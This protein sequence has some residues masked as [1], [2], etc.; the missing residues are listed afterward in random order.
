MLGEAFNRGGFGGV[1]AA[2]L[3]AQVCALFQLDQRL[4][5]RE[6]LL[7][8]RGR[9]LS[10]WRLRCGELVSGSVDTF[11]FLP[12]LPIKL[13]LGKQGLIVQCLLIVV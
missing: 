2:A 12:V 10:F 5:L 4:V 3:L 7:I 11:A 6:G 8:D 13:A 9:E 1:E